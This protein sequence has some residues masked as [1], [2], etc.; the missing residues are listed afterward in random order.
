MQ[1]L[2]SIGRG[3]CLC[4][5]PLGIPI[6]PLLLFRVLNQTLNTTYSYL[7][8]L[9]S[10]LRYPMLCMN[11]LNLFTFQVLGLA[12]STTLY[13]AFW[14]FGQ[15]ALFSQICCLFPI[16]AIDLMSKDTFSIILGGQMVSG[17]F[18]NDVR[19]QVCVIE[20]ELIF[21]GG[22]AKSSGFSRGWEVKDP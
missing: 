15:F 21:Q 8:C 22:G 13:L 3:K 20:K 12:I 6:D 1:I 7:I 19:N 9:K 17:A 14:Q 18:I 16:Y 5:Q 10:G 11:S 2:K 4:C